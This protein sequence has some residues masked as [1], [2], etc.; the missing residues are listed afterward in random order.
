[1]WFRLVL[2]GLIF[3]VGLAW[4]DWPVDLIFWA[5]LA[6]PAWPVSLVFWVVSQL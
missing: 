3:W 4:P 2:V 5:G 1:V 6:W